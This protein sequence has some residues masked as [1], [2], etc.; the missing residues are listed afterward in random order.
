MQKTKLA[1]MDAETKEYFVNDKF[2]KFIFS[3][4]INKA[5]LYYRVPGVLGIF[6]WVRIRT[7]TKRLLTLVDVEVKLDNTG[8]SQYLDELR[9]DRLKEFQQ[10]DLLATKNLEEMETSSYYRWRTL[11]KEFTT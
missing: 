10:L 2:D 7:K 8:T 3:L 6:E 1:F 9:D 5:K 11:R 4:D